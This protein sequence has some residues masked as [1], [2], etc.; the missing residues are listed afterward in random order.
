MNQFF[1][2][3][4]FW[5]VLK[6]LGAISKSQKPFSPQ[7]VVF[8]RLYLI[9]SFPDTQKEPLKK[10][11]SKFSANVLKSLW[12]ITHLP[13]QTRSKHATLSEHVGLHYCFQSDDS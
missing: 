3:S 6:K 5:T 10:S 2:G 11:H 1:L 13:G 9:I 4:F 8:F 7:I 12:D